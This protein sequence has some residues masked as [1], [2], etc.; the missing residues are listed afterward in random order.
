[1]QLIRTL[2]DFLKYGSSYIEF[3]VTW[4]TTLS[5]TYNFKTLF[6]ILNIWQDTN[7]KQFLTLC[8][9]VSYVTMDLYLH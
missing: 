1:M 5:M 8:I 6:D 4:N 2:I 7:E 9:A 3:V